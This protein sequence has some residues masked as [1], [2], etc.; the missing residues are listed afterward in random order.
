MSSPEG[1]TQWW[2][3]GDDLGAPDAIGQPPILSIRSPAGHVKADRVTD[4]AGYGSAT[5]QPRGRVR[6]AKLELRWCRRS[7]RWFQCSSASPFTAPCWDYEEKIDGW[8]VVA[9]VVASKVGRA[10]VW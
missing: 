5:R 3:C 8:R 2:I 6:P 7:F 4:Y 9:S 1:K 10:P